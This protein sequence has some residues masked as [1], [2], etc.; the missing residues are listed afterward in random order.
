MGYIWDLDCFIELLKINHNM[1]VCSV[2]Y[3]KP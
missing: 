1:E 2:M 3:P